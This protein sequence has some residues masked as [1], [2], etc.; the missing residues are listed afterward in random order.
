[1]QM[2]DNYFLIEF[3]ESNKIELKS[4]NKKQISL[5]SSTTNM[6]TTLKTNRITDNFNL[7]IPI[8]QNYHQEFHPTNHITRQ[9]TS[10]TSPQDHPTTH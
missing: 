2:V 5:K 8:R 4:L 6:A 9:S 10:Y 3:D 1:M 7:T